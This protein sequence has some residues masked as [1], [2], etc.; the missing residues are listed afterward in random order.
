MAKVEREVEFPAQGEISALIG[1]K[2]KAIMEESP[3]KIAITAI[4]GDLSGIEGEFFVGERIGRDVKEILAKH[5]SD[6]PDNLGDFG[7]HSYDID[8]DEDATAVISVEESNE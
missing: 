4:S 2:I 1:S 8:A 7:L 5:H 6:V 3:Q